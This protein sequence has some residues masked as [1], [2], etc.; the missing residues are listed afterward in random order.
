MMISISHLSLSVGIDSGETDSREELQRL[1]AQLENWRLSEEKRIMTT[2]R[3]A[4]R[5]RSARAKL[6]TDEALKLAQL[7][8]KRDRNKLAHKQ[9][10]VKSIILKVIKTI[11]GVGSMVIL[12]LASQLLVPILQFF[13]YRRV[14]LEC[15]STV[16]E[17]CYN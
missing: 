1:Y 9:D 4:S 15:G 2:T 7:A 6:V 8:T 12:L 10:I 14:S 11:L 3:Q 13:C 17:K 5:L 16:L